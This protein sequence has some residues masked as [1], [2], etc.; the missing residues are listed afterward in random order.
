V[1]CVVEVLAHEEGRGHVIEQDMDG[2]EA[3]KRID[4]VGGEARCV[5]LG[6]PGRV[7]PAVGAAGRPVA[8]VV[9]EDRPGAAGGPG[10][11]VIVEI[12]GADERRLVLLRQREVGVDHGAHVGGDAVRGEIVGQVIDVVDE[13]WAAPEWLS[14]RM[15]VAAD[16]GGRVSSSWR[17]PRR[18][19]A[20]CGRS[21]QAGAPRAPA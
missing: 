7:L 5:D 8:A 13:T 19:S 20:T 12:A 18:C 3:W 6:V 11:D 4:R 9:A 15:V 2:V 1:V 10:P 21:G 16:S 17:M 14:N